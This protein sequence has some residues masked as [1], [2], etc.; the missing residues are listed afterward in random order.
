MKPKQTNKKTRKTK[1]IKVVYK[2]IYE[3]LSPEE[4]KKADWIVESA[5]R[6]IFEEALKRIKNQVPNRNT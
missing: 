2:S 3:S 5:F 4:K 6:P 1:E